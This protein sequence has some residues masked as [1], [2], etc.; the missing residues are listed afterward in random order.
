MLTFRCAAMALTKWASTVRPPARF[1]AAAA[2]SVMM[3]GGIVSSAHADSMA[4][5]GC[6]GWRASLN[7]VARWGEAG[8]PYVRLVPS[9]ADNAERAHAA[10]RDH[11]WEQR[12]QPA[13]AQDRYGV[14]RY[15]YGASRCEF[16]VIE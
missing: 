5:G 7:C 9:P 13:I 12:C 4:V 15:Q 16:G 14:P 11:K 1:G 10:E 8:D 2:L 3:L 6:V